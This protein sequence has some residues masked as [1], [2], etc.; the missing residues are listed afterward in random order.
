MLSFICKPLKKWINKISGRR[1][2]DDPFDHPFA[3]L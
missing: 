3:I 2:D 1:D